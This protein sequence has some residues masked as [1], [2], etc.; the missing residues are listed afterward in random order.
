[1]VFSSL[2]FIF[3]YLPVV[4]AIYF[5]TPLKLRNLF[6]LFAN[7]IFYAWGEPIYVIIMI[8]SIFIDYTHGY[9]VEKYRHNDRLARFFVGS[10]VVFNLGILFIF[11]YLD[12]VLINLSSI[13]PN[14]QAT[15]SGALQSL[16]ENVPILDSIMGTGS[17]AL[18]IGISFYTFQTMS[19]TIDVYRNDAPMQK[20]LITFGTYVTLFPQLIAG[21]IVKYK[22]VATELDNRKET[23]DGFAWGVKMFIVGLCKKVLLANNIGLLW[24][25]IKVMPYD[26]L[27]MAT[28]WLGAIAFTFQIYFDFSGYSDMALGLGKMFGFTF[29][30]NFNYPYTSKSITEF[31][32]R[33]HI[34]LSSWF[35]EYVYIPLGG[36]RKGKLRTYIN[37][38]AVW[39]LTGVWHGA[40]W[41]FIIWGAYF[42]CILVLEKAFVLEW[43]KKA[44]S[45]VCHIY[46]MFLVIVSWAIFAVEGSFSEILPY[47]SAM[48]GG[49]GLIAN[50]DFLY[51]LLNFGIVIIV[52]IIASTPFVSN[53]VKKTPEK[54]FKPL[55]V[56][57]M[58][59]ALFVCTAYLVDSTY[60]PFLYFRF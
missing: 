38:I 35:R 47:L 52:C 33:W 27:P 21:P 11:K 30:K 50:T 51:Y 29:L 37:I 42:A 31:W 15:V 7:L 8:L 44:P 14:L 23:M 12:F 19:Y 10:S 1:M 16:S 43:L 39:F 4:L 45:I 57:L 32:R 54:V 58:F 41:N 36:N 60:N 55:S 22:E 25:T 48:F 20:N 53:S 56:I 46:T 18:P 24:D 40:E 26:S 6:L 13:F 28:A 34:S 17:L 5:L 9:L 59:I 2:M 3:V 49:T